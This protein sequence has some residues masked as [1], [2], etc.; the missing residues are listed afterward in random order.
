MVRGKKSQISSPCALA[1]ASVQGAC[2]K[3]SPASAKTPVRGTKW[4]RSQNWTLL[5]EK[6]TCG[7]TTP[8][9][10][11]EQRNGNG[12]TQE[13]EELQ[14]P[15]KIKSLGPV[16]ISQRVQRGAGCGGGAGEWWY[17]GVEF[18]RK[19]SR[20]SACFWRTVILYTPFLRP[21][22]LA[23]LRGH[24]TAT[25][26]ERWHMIERP[27]TAKRHGGKECWHSRGEGTKAKR[28][29]GTSSSLPSLPRGTSCP[30]AL[31]KTLLH[32][33]PPCLLLLFR[34]RRSSGSQAVCGSH[35]QTWAAL[36]SPSDIERPFGYGFDM[37]KHSPFLKVLLAV[38]FR[39]DL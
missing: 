15:G 33:C 20:A 21:A 12:V 37:I 24:H 19:L 14:G 6:S 16:T 23:W 10:V 8:G 9:R 1:V 27:D 26:S 25:L 5:G 31:G 29:G 7:A 38:C 32:L 28:S 13:N 30:P 22:F 4:Y 17:A 36:P 39:D 11:R 34:D 3:Q 18:R 2:R 35:R